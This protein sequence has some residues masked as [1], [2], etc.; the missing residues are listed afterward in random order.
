MI[1]FRY[2]YPDSGGSGVDGNLF[3][4]DVTIDAEAARPVPASAGGHGQRG[5]ERRKR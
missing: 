4:D 5:F 2:V 3:I 1:E